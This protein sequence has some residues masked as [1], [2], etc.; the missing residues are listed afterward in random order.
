[1]TAYLPKSCIGE[2]RIWSVAYNSNY[3]FV[4]GLQ[5]FYPNEQSLARDRGRFGVP[6]G[7]DFVPLEIFLDVKSEATDYDRVVLKTDA[8]LSFDKF[9]HLRVPR[10]LDWPDAVDE[11]GEPIKHLRIQMASSPVS[12]KL[13]LQDHT[14][15]TVP[16]VTLSATSD[17]YTA[18]YNIIDDLIMYQDPS[19][20]IRSERVDNF[21]F[22]F[23]RR[24][25]DPEQLLEDLHGLQRLIRE[26]LHLAAG[27][28]ANIDQLTDEG[29]NELVNIRRD[30]NEAMEQLYT[31]F[32]AIAIAFNREDAQAAL[33]SASRMDVRI[34][35]VAWHMLRDDFTPLIKL[36]IEGVLFTHLSNK[37]G[38]A[39]SSIAIADVYGLNSKADAIYPEI[40]TR[41]EEKSSGR[42]GP[43]RPSAKHKLIKQKE[44]FIATSWSTLA[45]V[46]GISI[47]RH[48]GYKLYPVRINLEER[49][50]HAVSDYMFS[51]RKKRRQE[52]VTSGTGTHTPLPEIS[53][54]G[55]SHGLLSHPH[56]NRTASTIELPSLHRTRSTVSIASTANSVAPSRS[57]SNQGQDDAPTHQDKF[58]TV[59]RDDVAEM[60]RRAS[61][62]RTFL[63]ILFEA[64][65]IVLTYKV[66]Q[67]CQLATDVQGDDRKKRKGFSMPDVVD[68]RI[69]IPQLKYTNKVW[70]YEDIYEHV[71]RGEYG[72]V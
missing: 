68:F 40:L 47:V 11:H 30:S 20:R 29:R 60:R 45:P 64:T 16:R 25:R 15:V 27:Y 24:E 19:H 58:T 36:D 14:T 4:K 17:H 43:V 42:R 70:G 51:A 54:N 48:L 56:T 52:S 31:V 41:Y 69:K 35:G 38:S 32:D 39:E 10:G 72:L 71:K 61:A 66:T 28:D 18:L 23:D 5:A 63:D 12:M 2:F 46:G 37:D 33:K 62:N 6:K 55:G 34:G 65:S 50:G 9:N 44:P 1:M 22:A 8:A 7:L 13:I 53:E 67:Q 57:G 21:I 49:V 3:A 26:M 59:P